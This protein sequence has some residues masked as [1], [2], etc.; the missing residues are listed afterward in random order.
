MGSVTISASY[1]A[2][3]DQIGHEVAERLALAFL[4]RAIPAAVARQLRLSDETANTLDQRAPS[5][6]DR[7]VRS[8][9][10]LDATFA[11]A[12]LATTSLESSEAFRATTEQVLVEV[13]DTT[14]AVILGRAAMV[15]L[16]DRPDVLRVR[17]DGPLDARIAQVVETGI[18]EATARE[19]Q[20]DVDSARRNYASYFYDVSQDDIHLYHLV[21]DSTS[22]AVDVCVELIVEAARALFARADQAT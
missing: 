22:L 14:G 21:I 8:F 5:L 3:G 18:D 16:R 6:W 4:D 15:V 13:A 17:L 1:G 2:H 7:I 10:G 9:S 20:K 19:T 12:T 11:G